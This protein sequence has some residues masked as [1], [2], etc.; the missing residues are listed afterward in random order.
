MNILPAIPETTTVFI[1][2]KQKQFPTLNILIN[3]HSLSDENTAVCH[4]MDER[5][6]EKADKN[7]LTFS[8]DTFLNSGVWNSYW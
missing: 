1:P 7:G 2:I 5:T 6:Y 8:I 4:K 3:M